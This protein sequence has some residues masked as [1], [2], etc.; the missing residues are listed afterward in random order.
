MPNN[1]ESNG[2]LLTGKV[3]NAEA[4]Q[5]GVACVVVLLFLEEEACF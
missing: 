3:L 4:R 2:V 1:T 5:R